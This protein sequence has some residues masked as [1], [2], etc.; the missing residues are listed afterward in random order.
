MDELPSYEGSPDSDVF[1]NELVEKHHSIDSTA[2]AGED[3]ARIIN[4][5]DPNGKGVS[6][7]FWDKNRKEI[8]K[9][10]SGQFVNEGV[11]WATDSRNTWMEDAMVCYNR[12]RRPKDGC[13]DYRD[14]S[15]RIGRPTKEGQAVLKDQY[16]LGRRDPCICDF[17]PVKSGV[18]TKINLK[19]GMYDK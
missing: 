6:P 10:L 12:H 9:Q 11:A 5:T 8:I 17:C 18:Q 15:K 13:P 4:I 3:V 16:K 2:H 7:E 19:A 1:L 14:D